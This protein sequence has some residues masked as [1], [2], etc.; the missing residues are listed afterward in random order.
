MRLLWHFV[1]SNI[2]YN[3][4]E[5]A[6][7]YGSSVLFTLLYWYFNSDSLEKESAGNGELFVSVAFYATL[8]AFFTQKKKTSVKYL[9]SLPLSKSQMLLNKSLADI[10]F[11]FP[12]IYIV[13]LGVYY[14]NLNIH[15]PL[16]FLTL[17]LIVFVG[18]LWMFDQEI[19][20]PRLDN[21]KSNFLNRLIYVRKST[22]FIFR[23]ILVFYLIAVI[24]LL[25]IDILFKEYLIIIFLGVSAFMKFQ[26]SLYLMRDETLSYFRPKRDLFRVGWKLALLLGP[27]VLMQL[28]SIGLIN[29]YGNQKIFSDIYYSNLEEVEK[30]YQ[31]NENWDVKGKD[32]FTPIL[33]AIH[34]GDLKIVKYMLEHGA[35]LNLYDKISRG[36]HKGKRAL[37]LA[38]D[39]DNSNLVDFLLELERKKVPA[40]HFYQLAA[41]LKYAS[42]KCDPEILKVILKYHP[43][44]NQVDENGHT[45]LHN[46]A[47]ANCYAGI[48]LLVEAGANVDIKDKS[49]NYAIDYVRDKKFAY[50]LNWK[51]K[52]PRKLEDTKKTRYLLK[53]DIASRLLGN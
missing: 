50:Y 33:A 2:R 44:I 29:P 51:M 5:L 4:I 9:L 22:E 27:V 48:V 39:S 43:D 30:F 7:S 24:L 46:Q 16:T 40:G 38:I 15:F 35:E 8:Y 21:A 13:M 28:K 37:H 11:F 18:S 19:E 53:R 31:E 10:I 17:V 42:K 49:S 25:K 3:K 23:S 52:E 45:A 41:P 14:T 26:R 6:I 36:T 20:Q 12:A 1:S 32:E 34:L 47:K